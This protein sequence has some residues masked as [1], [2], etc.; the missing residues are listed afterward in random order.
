MDRIT[1]ENLP[2]V[3]GEIRDRLTQIEKHLESL[4]PSE[5]SAKHLMTISEAASFL[6]TTIKTIR[7]NSLDGAGWPC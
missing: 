2:A 4:G 3:V 7:I 6:R 1:F 5:S